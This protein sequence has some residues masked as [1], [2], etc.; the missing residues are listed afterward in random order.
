MRCDDC[1][2]ILPLNIGT[3][4]TNILRPEVHQGLSQDYWRE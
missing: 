2:E 4:R 1:N 3:N